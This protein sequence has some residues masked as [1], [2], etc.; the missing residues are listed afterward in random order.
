[1]VAEAEGLSVEHRGVWLGVLL[2]EGAAPALV[3]ART[4]GVG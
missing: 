3:D 4:L 2:G 1:M